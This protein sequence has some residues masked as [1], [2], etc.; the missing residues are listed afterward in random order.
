MAGKPFGFA[1]GDIFGPDPSLQRMRLRNQRQAASGKNLADVQIAEITGQQPGSE[2]ASGLDMLGTAL[3]TDATQVLGSIYGAGGKGM[4]LPGATGA[5]A[6][7]SGST[8]LTA[9]GG[10]LALVGAVYFIATRK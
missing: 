4:A 1:A 3:G 9:I 2:V 7:T 10:L 6:T 8:D 5:V